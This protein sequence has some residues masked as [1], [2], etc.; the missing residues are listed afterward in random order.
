[1]TEI[2]PIELPTK[3]KMLDGLGRP[4]TQSLFLELGYPTEAIYTLKEEHY[5]YKGKLFPSIKK[6]YLLAEDPTEYT[7]A[8]TYF[9]SWKHWLRLCEN[10]KVRQHIDEWREELEMKLRSRAVQE[11]IR[12]SSKGKIVA[13]KWMVDRG[14]G[15]KRKPG[16]PSKEEIDSHL[17]NEAKTDSEYG[18]DVVRL[19]AVQR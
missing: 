19:Q 12:N 11:M 9:L 13:S 8:T 1:M 17:A 4:F 18:A 2:K 15:E 5:T 7:F 16:R 6:L 14:W 10:K 3:D